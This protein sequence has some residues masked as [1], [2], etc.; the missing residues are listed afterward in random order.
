MKMLGVRKE[1]QNGGFEG[2]NEKHS[3]THKSYLWELPYA[4]ALI[5][6]NLRTDGAT[7][8][9]GVVNGSRI[10]LFARMGLCPEF[11]TRDNLCARRI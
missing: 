2:Y 9:G 10:K 8:G 7:G 1:S 11:K 5:L 3:W 6:S 4:K